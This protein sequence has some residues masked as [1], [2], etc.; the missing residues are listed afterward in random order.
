MEEKLLMEKGLETGLNLDSK[1]RSMIFEEW[2]SEVRKVFDIIQFSGEINQE[3][4]FNFLQALMNAFGG[5]DSYRHYQI[6]D[7]LV[8]YLR[9]NNFSEQNIYL[10]FSQLR[11]IILKY[12]YQQQAAGAEQ[13]FSEIEEILSKFDD[14]ET[15]IQRN[16]TLYSQ[17]EMEESGV[18][19]TSLFNDFPGAIFQIDGPRLEGVPRLN[20]YLGRACGIDPAK[21]NSAEIWKKLIHNQ[22]RKN[23]EK[24][25]TNLYQQQ[26]KTYSIQY[27]LRT[28]NG[29][30]TV[31][32]EGIIEFN[33]GGLAS[34]INGVILRTPAFGK[35]KERIAAEQSKYSKLQQISPFFL[36]I[37]SEDGTVLECNQRFSAGTGGSSKQMVGTSLLQW[38]T[39]PLKPEISAFSGFK[40]LFDMQ[41]E[42]EILLKDAKGY[43]EVYRSRLAAFESGKRKNNY[44]FIA[45]QSNKLPEQLDNQIKL[46]FDFQQDLLFKTESDQL[47]DKILEFAML[48][49]PAADAGSLLH[50]LP[51]GMHFVAAK[52]FELDRLKNVVLCRSKD[53]KFL[54]QG[55]HFKRLKAGSVIRGASIFLNEARQM[56]D[57]KEFELLTEYG[58]LD[59]II[60]NLGGLV[61]VDDSPQYVINLDNFDPTR[62]FSESD[63]FLLDIYMQ[64]LG[65]VF[66]SKLLREK[67]KSTEP[68][69]Q[70]SFEESPIPAAIIQDGLLKLVNDKFSQFTG[71]SPEETAQLILRKIVHPAE[72]D[73]V[74]KV[75]AADLIEDSSPSEIEFRLIGKSKTELNC[76]GYISRIQV[77]GKAAV[78]LQ[79]VKT[80]KVKPVEPDLLQRQKMETVGTLTTGFAHDFNNILGAIS[81]SAQL[82]MADPSH[83]QTQKRA[84]II[85]NMARRAGQLTKQLMAF[86]RPEKSQAIPFNLNEVIKDSMPLIEKSKGI[87]VNLELDLSLKLLPVEGDPDQFAQ[88]LLNLAVN[89]KD[90]M[91]EGGRL[92]IST[93][94]IEINESYLQMDPAFRPGWYVNLTVKDEG[95]GIPADLR[96]RIFEPFFT[97][98]DAGTGLGLSIVYGIIKNHHGV[99]L[100]NSEEQ[101]GTTFDLFFP[102]G[103]KKAKVE[104]P[105]EP[106]LTIPGTGTI[107][108]VDDEKELREIIRSILAYLG[109][110]P[111]IA[112]GGEEALRIYRQR[113][114]EIDLVLLDFVMPGM[115]GN[116]TYEELK[117]LNPK[118]KVLICSGYS[119]KEGVHSLMMNGIAGVLPKPFTLQSISQKLKTVLAPPAAQK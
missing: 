6:I 102:A 33:K 67:Q 115:D 28:K 90:A 35:L 7:E 30:E 118:V 70:I 13:N 97:T 72:H 104:I 100:L 26:K 29:F 3:K 25:F 85:Y 10:I 101:K 9:K 87:K 22:D 41:P 65:I 78:L 14:L 52:G 15:F 86:A 57:K 108:A 36:A 99:I 96:E 91:R 40:E 18:D 84:E 79:M 38:M 34:R 61:H 77:D 107:L 31:I 113:M 53:A 105:K 54:E 117:K 116:E 46:L 112:S 74:E 69:L 8:P 42:V 19:F 110:K 44:L 55:E 73:M 89:A 93:K 50:I 2:L 94:N 21:F 63:K 64:Q 83:P 80:D 88:V 51:D 62:Q 17:L 66:K 48:L 76:T 58:R 68:A 23:L 1:R 24:F 47:F 49:I 71:Y 56:L 119:E 95:S 16:L 60:S 5:R 92:Q 103:K 106:E 39:I 98:K 32:E 27:R 4:L 12:V 45:W 82:I 111:I 81:P 114:R 109:Y 11:N 20:R 43:P 75:L 59:S 37:C